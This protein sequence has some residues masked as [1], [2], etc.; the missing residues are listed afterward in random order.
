MRPLRK[1]VVCGS[2]HR[3]H[4]GLRRLFRELEA[5]GCRVLSPLSVDFYDV[6]EPVVRTSHEQGF[7]TGELEKFHLR[8]IREADLIWIHAPQGHI[9]TSTAYELGFAA[10]LQKPLFSLHA[11]QDEM[12]ASQIL[13]VRSVFEALDAAA[14][15]TPSAGPVPKP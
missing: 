15:A 7:S 13:V 1:V 10:A 3:D 9:G 14:C 8:A 11:S 4:D 6:S 2:Y 5:T 12:L